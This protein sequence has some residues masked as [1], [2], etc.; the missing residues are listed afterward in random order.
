M[1][2]D[3]F[4]VSF[5]GHTVFRPFGFSFPFER[6]Y[7]LPVVL[8]VDHG[9][10]LSLGGVERLV[11]PA[12]GGIAVVGPFPFGIGVVHNQSKAGK[13]IGRAGRAVKA[14]SILRRFVSK[15]PLLVCILDAF[16][17]GLNE[18]L[19]LSDGCPEVWGT[20]RIPWSAYLAIEFLAASIFAFTAS[21]LKLAP[22]CIGGNSI[23]VIAS[24]S[25]CC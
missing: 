12:H 10:A 1:R 23:A 14:D 20:R 16:H 22:L 5:R 15:S 18:A 7:A 17:D 9:P 19:C 6:K 11:Q 25:T 24:F 13:R 21:R 4:V 3:F 2:L 8:H